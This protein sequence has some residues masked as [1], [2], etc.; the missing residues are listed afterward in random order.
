MSFLKINFEQEIKKLNPVTW[1]YNNDP[2]NTVNIGY[3][4]EEM[5]DIDAFSF[6]VEKDPAGNPIGIR[7]EILSVYAIEALKACFERIEKLESL[8]KSEC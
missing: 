8:I 2:S 6:A 1:I 5:N 3:I 7:Y 4:A